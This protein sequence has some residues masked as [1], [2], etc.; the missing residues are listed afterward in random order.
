[1]ARTATAR[2]ASEKQMHWV[3]RMLI[4]KG[5]KKADMAARTGFDYADLTTRTAGTWLDIL[6]SASKPASADDP[7]E[8]G[9]YL[10]ADGNVVKMVWNRE[11]SRMYGKQLEH[12]TGFVFVAGCATGV[13]A[14]MLMDAEAAR[15]YGIRTS[16]C[17]NCGEE[18]TAGV[19]MGIGIGPTCGPKVMGKPSY[20]AAVRA[21]KVSQGLPVRKAKGYSQAAMDARVESIPPVIQSDDQV[22]DL[23][24]HFSK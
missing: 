22:A 9:L 7:T 24:A 13:K 19:S 11:G 5:I 1:M 17:V 6:F 16:H 4:E 2:P 12:G 14:S 18:L 3:D 23:L 15:A 20:S 21:W 10:K 8:A